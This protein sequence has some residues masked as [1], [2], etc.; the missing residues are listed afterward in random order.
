[1][2]NNMAV[3]LERT[4]IPIVDEYKFLRVIFDRKLS[5]NPSL[6]T[7]E[8]KMQQSTT[9]PTSGSPHRMGSQQANPSKIVQVTG[10][11]T[12]GQ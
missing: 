10:L 11:F 1:M 2:H 7:P 4:K 12:A 6:E 5:F 8:I 9:A 3:K